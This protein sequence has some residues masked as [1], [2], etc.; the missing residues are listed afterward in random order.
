MRNV[1]TDTNRQ[2]PKNRERFHQLYFFQ[3]PRLCIIP[4]SVWNKKNKLQKI[5]ESVDNDGISSRVHGNLH[6]LP[7]KSLSFEE[8]ENVKDFISAYARDNVL[9]FQADCQTINRGVFSFSL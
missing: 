7:S 5:A 6:M 1:E 8:R 2:K 3:G 9:P 4:F